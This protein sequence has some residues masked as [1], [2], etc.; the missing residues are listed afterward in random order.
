[1]TATPHDDLTRTSF[2]RQVALFSG[3]DS[4]FARRSESALA[5]VEPVDPA[6]TV[7]DVACGAGHVAEQLS[8]HVRAVLGVDLTRELLELGARRMDEAGITN[9]VLQEGNAASLP[10]VDASFDLVCC[11][12][13]VHH[14]ADPAATIA[15]MARVCRPGGRVAVADLV[16]LDAD[17]RDTYDAVHRRIDPSHVRVLL[18]SELAALLET[19]VGPLAY[20][21]TSD[22]SAFPVEAFFTE[23]TD[24]VGVMGALEAELAGGAPTGFAP[25][26]GDEGE[27]LVSFAVTVVQATRP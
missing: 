19:G 26:L 24:R 7:L 17:G 10:F 13:A 23:Q 1:M 14:F 12:T 22:L 15:E 5:W 8:P 11:R 20:A 27:M 9:V 3:P 25:T 4:P 6:M 18:E 16:V 21:Q 2:R